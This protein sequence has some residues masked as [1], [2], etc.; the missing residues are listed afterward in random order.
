VGP[1]AIQLIESCYSDHAVPAAE[2]VRDV[3]NEVKFSHPCFFLSPPPPPK[4]NPAVVP[5][6]WLIDTVHFNLNGTIACR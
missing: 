6:T 2:L 1:R 5:S 3:K 4:G